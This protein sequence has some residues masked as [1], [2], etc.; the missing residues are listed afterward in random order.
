MNQPLIKYCPGTLAAGHQTY[1]S[2][3]LRRLFAGRKV[4]H[5]L[6]YD[7]PIAGGSD[8]DKFRENL[9]RVSIS[10]VQEKFSLLLE[11]NRLRLVGRGEQG[12]YILKP[13]P[14]GVKHAGQMPANEHLTMQIARQVYGIE[15]AENALIFFGNGEPAYITL[16]FDVRD[17]GTKRAEEDFASLAGRTP[18][19]HGDWFKYTG[20]YLE[21][22]ELM[23]TY[24]PAWRIES[25]KLFRLLIFNYLFSN[26]D[27]HFKNFSVLETEFGD[28]RLAPA[29][30][31][32]NSRLH[33]NDTDFALDDGLLPGKDRKPGM[34]IRGQFMLL[35]E[36][37]SIS[38]R[39]I[40]SVYNA[41]LTR[42]DMVTSM[43]NASFL[44]DDFKRHYLESY[45]SRLNTL[46]A[47]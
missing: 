1:S 43:T 16:R 8:S 26:G 42:T 39:L 20:S 40:T 22:F 28:F 36:K 11:K 3:C 10:G 5:V 6:P 29:Y 41:M 4:H 34:S 27:A 24:L 19:T 33:I 18:H 25:P 9:T 7:S 13:V 12:R 46:S 31:L 14:S 2:T 47:P 30:D 15:T 38:T 17:D 45:H 21:L 37:A 35:G 23:R 44:S 32:L